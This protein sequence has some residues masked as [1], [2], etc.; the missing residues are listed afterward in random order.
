MRYAGWMAALLAGAAAAWLAYGSGDLRKELA[1]AREDLASL[2]S[3]L[4]DAE[5]ELAALRGQRDRLAGENRAM[6]TAAE[7]PARAPIPADIEAAVPEEAAEEDREA[8]RRNRVA[9]A[10]MG[11]LS[12]IA[13]RAFYDELGLS[14][15]ARSELRPLIV[16]SMDR[17]RVAT[18]RAFREGNVPAREIKRIEDESEAWLA[19]AVAEVL[20]PEE[21]AG[22][23]AYQDYAEQ[24]L[25][26]YLLDGQLTMLAQGLA[27]DGRQVVKEV[28]A[29]ELKSSIDAFKDSDSMFTLDGY[30]QAQLIG[31]RTGLERL[32]TGGLDPGQYQ[33]ASGFV[34]Q[35]ATMFEAMSQ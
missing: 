34:H 3:R 19:E 1:I 28:F 20:T 30:N 2:S 5:A 9:S 33:E 26:E 31:L 27:P 10:Q 12:D 17:V 18:E 24:V 14:A 4:N 32:E 7:R 23:D 29:E 8:T 35:A 25:Y 11:A 16:E 13:Y 22:W 6:Q 21:Q 15:E